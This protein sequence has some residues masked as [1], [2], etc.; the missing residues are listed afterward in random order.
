MHPP[1]P[2]DLAEVLRA[3]LSLVD[4]DSGPMEKSVTLC[5]LKRALRAS[6]T[7]LELCIVPKTAQFSPPARLSRF[8][9][10]GMGIASMSEAK[11]PVSDEHIRSLG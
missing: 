6:I 2:Q 7:E 1:H 4:C 11:M 5:E 10:S 8:N 3:T 9:Q